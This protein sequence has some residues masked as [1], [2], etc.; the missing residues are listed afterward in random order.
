MKEMIEE[1]SRYGRATYR[2]IYGDWTQ[3]NLAGWRTV[4]LENAIEPVHQ[5]SYTTGK[6]STDSTLII[7]AMDILYSGTVQGFC[8]VSSDSDY[9][10]L[11]MRVRKA[12]LFVMGIGRKQTPQAF[13]NACNV[14]V[15]VEN[16]INSDEAEAKP[17]LTNHEAIEKNKVLHD[18]LNRA[19][20]IVVQDGG[21]AHLGALGHTLNQIDPSFD[22]RTYGYKSLSL[23]IKSLPQ[24]FILEEA[25]KTGPSSVYYVRM[26]E[27]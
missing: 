12:G 8:I 16:L 17:K 13:V 14:F 4:M 26:I 23:L 6:N 27:E 7:D 15:Y 11:C 20:D 18:L 10:R 1:V 19:Y 9:T 25:K 3:P 24:H 22:S 21:W 2:Q 5:I